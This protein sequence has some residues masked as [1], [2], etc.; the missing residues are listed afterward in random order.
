M[1]EQKEEETEAVE[2]LPSSLPLPSE[3]FHEVTEPEEEPALSGIHQ[4]AELEDARLSHPQVSTV[5][6]KHLLYYC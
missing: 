1:E 2:E 6:H 4:A 3:T 5:K